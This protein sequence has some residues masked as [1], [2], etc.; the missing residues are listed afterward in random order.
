MYNFLLPLCGEIKITITTIRN[1]IDQLLYDFTIQNPVTWNE[2]K[3]QELRKQQQQQEQCSYPSLEELYNK[4]QTALERYRVEYE[5]VHG[6]Q[7]TNELAEDE[8]D[9]RN[10]LFRLRLVIATHK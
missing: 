7:P 10:W 3:A 6:P 2:L 8:I 4:R 9:G 5:L 1:E